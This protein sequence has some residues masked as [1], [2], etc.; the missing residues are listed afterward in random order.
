MGLDFSHCDA[1]WSYTGFNHFRCRVA[2]IIMET[3]KTIDR[4]YDERM[5][6]RYLMNEPIYPF[7]D[8]SDCDGKLTPDEL[9]QIIP[10]LEDAVSKIEDVYDKEN[11]E[12]LLKGMK[13]ALKN[14]EDLRFH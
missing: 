13:L 1:H 3:E 7:I 10:Q 8:H 14:N 12:K 5:I 9:K 6:Y 2:S 4:L 11:G